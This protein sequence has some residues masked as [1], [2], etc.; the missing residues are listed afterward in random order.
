MQPFTRKLAETKL[1]GAGQV[2]KVEGR[3]YRAEFEGDA[4]HVR[5]VGVDGETRYPIAHV[6]G[7]KNVYYFL[8]P[9]DK[10]RLQVLPI[11]YDV[12][13]KAWYDTAGSTAGDGSHRIRLSS[14][15]LT[16]AEI[17]LLPKIKMTLIA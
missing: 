12:R 17:F 5:E 11:A 6:M 10:G 4:G 3:T 13:S 7:G 8:T 2:V 15:I 9:L 16:H 1:S 14:L